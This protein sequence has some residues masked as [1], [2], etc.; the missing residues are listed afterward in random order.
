[1]TARSINPYG[2]TLEITSTGEDPEEVLASYIAEIERQGHEVNEVVQSPLLPVA[3]QHMRYDRTVRCKACGVA[4][5]VYFIGDTLH[6]F[7][8]FAGNQCATR[9]MNVL[10]LG[11]RI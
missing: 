9:Q 2:D 10:L 11:R 7:S 6:I 3:A 4:M 1:M 5:R 8:D